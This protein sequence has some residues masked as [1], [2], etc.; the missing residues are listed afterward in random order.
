MTFMV[1]D[2]Y[3]W[4]EDIA[5]QEAS[6]CVVHPA[7]AAAPAAATVA[8]VSSDADIYDVPRR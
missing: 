2:P 8:S 3:L 6:D 4:L 5:G 1:N 7:A